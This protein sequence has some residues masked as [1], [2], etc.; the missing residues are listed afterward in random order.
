V[1]ALEDLHARDIVRAS[2][3]LDAE[4][5]DSSRAEHTAA[6]ALRS[7]SPSSQVEVED[8]ATAPP[9][10]QSSMDLTLDLA[11]SINKAIDQITAE[12]T[13]FCI[14]QLEKSVTLNTAL[15]L[16]TDVNAIEDELRVR[17]YIVRR[18]HQYIHCLVSRSYQRSWIIHK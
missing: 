12:L 5:L 14:D 4:T 3:D 17:S 1:V 15:D 13:A 2:E 7:E 18:L 16:N 6:R 11:A 9:V 8:L 10:A